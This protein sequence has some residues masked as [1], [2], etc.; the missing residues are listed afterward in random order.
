MFV[1]RSSKLQLSAWRFSGTSRGGR[2]ITIKAEVV[3]LVMVRVVL[4]VVVVWQ[5][6]AMV[7]VVVIGALAI[8]I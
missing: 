8:C 2:G 3:L 7:F 1:V 4:V 5:C 6:V